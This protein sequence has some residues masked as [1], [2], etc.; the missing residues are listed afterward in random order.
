[1]LK[2]TLTVRI[3]TAAGT[4]KRTRILLQAMKN[5]AAELHAAPSKK[6]Q[7][8]DG[9]GGVVCASASGDARACSAAEAVRQ[10]AQTGQLA[11]AADPTVDF[12]RGYK[13]MK[14]WGEWSG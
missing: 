2:N 5:V 6:R 14:G 3:D 7:R 8:A 13:R 10:V 1:M 9:V 4:K 12:E 11:H